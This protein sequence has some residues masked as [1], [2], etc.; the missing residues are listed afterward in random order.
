MPES[1][2]SSKY[3]LN[4]ESTRAAWLQTGS[5]LLKLNYGYWKKSAVAVILRRA[6]ETHCSERFL[7]VVLVWRYS[8]ESGSC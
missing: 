2:T 8:K 4:G 6:N 7:V 1:P 5:S 3:F